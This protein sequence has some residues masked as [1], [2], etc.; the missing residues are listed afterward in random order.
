MKIVII[1]KT[2]YKI[3]VINLHNS[4]KKYYIKT[5]LNILE[6]RNQWNIL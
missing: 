4:I 1:E 5:N 2:Q 3:E 6:I